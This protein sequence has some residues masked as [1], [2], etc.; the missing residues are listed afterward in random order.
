MAKRPP[1]PEEFLPLSEIA[2][3]IL[4]TLVD[5]DR[6]GYAILLEVERRTAGRLELLPG[7]LYRAIHRFRKQGLV[8]ERPGARSA[9]PRRRVHRLTPLGR[10][11]LAAEAARLAAK[12]RSARGSG[13]LPQ[14]GLP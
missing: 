6:H 1:A 10:R 13:L 8:E 9:D 7:S 3:E 12:V 5:E 14:G 11:V 4:L 2:W